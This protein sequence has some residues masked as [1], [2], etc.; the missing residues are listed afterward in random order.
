MTLVI[1]NSLI[2]N[3]GYLKN[4]IIKGYLKWATDKKKFFLGRKLFQGIK[5]IKGYEKRFEK[6]EKKKRI[7][8]QMEL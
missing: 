5:T 2:K 1:I 6:L 4:D 7:C 3:E 8:N